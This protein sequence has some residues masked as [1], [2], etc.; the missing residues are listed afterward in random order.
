M[1]SLM[2]PVRKNGSLGLLCHRLAMAYLAAM[3]TIIAH[4][5]IASYVGF[6]F[7]PAYSSTLP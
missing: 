1:L 3:L 5:P 2:D 7:V 4:A 6:E